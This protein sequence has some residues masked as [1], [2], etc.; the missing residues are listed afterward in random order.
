M[1]KL[2]AVGA[3][4]EKVELQTAF[5][6]ESPR[7]G[8]KARL[9]GEGLCF[10]ASGNNGDRGGGLPNSLV[11]VVSHLGCSARARPVL[12]VV[13]SLL[14]LAKEEEVGIPCTR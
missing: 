8:A 9:G 4:C 1:T 5:Y 7:E 10:G 6:L 11:S 3:L 14:M 12:Y 2:L 13:S